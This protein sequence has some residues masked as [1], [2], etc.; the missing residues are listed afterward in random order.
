MTS[1]HALY[2]VIDSSSDIREYGGE[3]AWLQYHPITTLSSLQYLPSHTFVCLAGMVLSPGPVQK[4]ENIEGHG[5]QESVPIT[6]F[7][8]RAKDGIVKVEAWRDTSEYA[9]QL[10]A[11]RIYYF[12]GIKKV[13]TDRDKVKL[14]IVRYQ[15][16]T[17]HYA[18][19]AA[20]EEEIKEATEDNTTGATMVSPTAPV[21]TKY[22]EENADWVSLSVLADIIS[23]GDVRRLEGA[24]QVPSVLIKPIGD[25]ITYLCC[26]DCGKGIYEKEKCVS[27]RQPTPKFDIVQTF[28]G[29]TTR[30]RSMQSSSMFWSL[31]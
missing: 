9:K 11:G 2:G 13:S 29:K 16:Y 27:V 10:V 21:R 8:L 14:S 4:R 15:K 18:C 22:K 26:A 3:A 25:R 19:E 23:G 7:D 1:R 12:E 5:S 17:Q 31:L 20:L 30:T 6:N 28:V 24:V